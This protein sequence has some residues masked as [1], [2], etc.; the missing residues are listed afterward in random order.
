MPGGCSALRE[1][2]H[3]ERRCIDDADVVLLE[4]IQ[5]VEQHFVVQT[6]MA[7]RQHTLYRSRL[8]VL[9][10]PFQILRLQVG[11]AHMTY[12][13][14][15]AK[16][17]QSRQSLVYNFLQSAGQ[18]A[19][20]LH[21]VHINQVDEVDVKA[22]HTLIYTRRDAF[23]R[24]IPVVLAILSIASHLRGEVVFVTRNLL[25]CLAQHDFGLQMTIVGRHIDEVDAIIYCHMY[26]LDAFGLA[27]VVE[28]ATQRRGSKAEVAHAHTC[29]SYFIIYHIYNVLLLYKR[30]NIKGFVTTECLR[31]GDFDTFAASPEPSGR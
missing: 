31:T 30:R 3:G 4:E 21:I 20:E 14:L 26:S 7:E 5:I 8:G 22:L 19:L 15:F 27:D 10:H 29:F 6:I 18:V 16:F 25:Q 13:S 9:N 17:N 23:G 11:D 2:S 1:Q 24:I 12:H 28:H